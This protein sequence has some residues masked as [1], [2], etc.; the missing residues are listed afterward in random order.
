MVVEQTSLDAF[1]LI[2]HSGELGTQEY[3]V[4]KAIKANPDWTAKEL[5]DLTGIEIN[6]M[7]GRINGLSNKIVRMDDNKLYQVV[8]NGK[9]A[10]TITGMTVKVWEVIEVN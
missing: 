10:C 4:L 3:E 8:S 7:S 2:K 6:A 9:R 5:S 1:R